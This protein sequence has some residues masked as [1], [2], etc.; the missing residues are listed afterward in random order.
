MI[1]PLS[2]YKEIE[3]FADAT[4]ASFASITDTVLY[5][6]IAAF[7]KRDQ[8]LGE[9]FFNGN[10]PTADHFMRVVQE[11]FGTKVYSALS[12]YVREKEPGAGAI[13]TILGINRMDAR[14]YLEAFS[15]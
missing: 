10:T 7:N 9:Y 3:Q 15:A 11:A 4:G 14:G 5:G 12:Q 8:T 1:S 2:V 13:A 6:F